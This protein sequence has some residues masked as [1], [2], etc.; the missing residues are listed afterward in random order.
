MVYNRSIMI[1]RQIKDEF[2]KCLGEYPAV[3]ITGP[4]QSGKTTLARALCGDRPYHSFED[5]IVRGYFHDD[6]KGFLANCANG[7]IFDEAQNVPELFS[8]LQGMIDESPKTGRFVITGSRNFTLAEQISQSLAGRIARLELLPFSSGELISGGLLPETLDETLFKGS[9]PPVFDRKHRP[10]R[11]YSDYFATYIQRD[12]RQIK[13]VGDL[14]VFTRFM[15]LCAGSVG[16]LFNQ[17]RVASDCGVDS[18]TVRSWTSILEASYVATVVNPHHANL[19]KRLV[20]TPKLYF[21]DTGLACHLLGIMEPAQLST[22]PLR[23]ALFENWVFTELAKHLRNKGRSTEIDFWRTHSGQEID[24]IIQD[25]ALLHGIEVK[26]GQT[27]SSEAIKKLSTA[28][29][30]FEPGERR[31]MIVYGGD[32]H[33]SLHGCQLVPWRETESVFV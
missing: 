29:S 13:Q 32:Q 4:R 14:D 26:A 16:Q 17:S 3:A 10:E 7:A 33:L 19:R 27:V 30:D 18:K 6:P 28:L 21:Y 25:G 24:F 11:W 12:V 1:I 22:H 23:G 5:P 9:Y 20:K 8:H 31:G 2:A 15:R